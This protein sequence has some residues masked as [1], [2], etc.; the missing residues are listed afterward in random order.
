MSTTQLVLLCWLHKNHTE[1]RTRVCAQIGT[2]QGNLFNRAACHMTPRAINHRAGRSVP[3]QLLRT[4]VG[5][6][7]SEVYYVV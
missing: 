5:P 7:L 3:R 4:W 1:K 6:A 2:C